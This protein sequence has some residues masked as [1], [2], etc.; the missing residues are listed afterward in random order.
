MNRLS[1]DACTY[2]RSVQQSVDPL[3]YMLE[4]AKYVHDRRCMMRLGVVGGNTVSTLKNEDLVDTES[5]LMNITR[6]A[7]KCPADQYGPHLDR[8]GE[9]KVHLQ[10]CQIVR[11]KAVPGATWVP[12]AEVTPRP[13]A[14]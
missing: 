7:S 13:A 14:R 11:Y 1:H 2:R 3:A 5:D 12:P 6:P 4:P 9:E 8:S 10:P